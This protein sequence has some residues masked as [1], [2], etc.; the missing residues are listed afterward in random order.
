MEDKDIAQPELASI[1]L[2]APVSIVVPTFREVENIPRLIERIAALAEAYDA[3]FELIFADDN[4]QDGSVEAVESCGYPWVRILVRTE[5]PGLS[6]SVIDGMKAA[7]HPA[8]V[9]M[10]C[11]LSHPPERVP[12]LILALQS[13]QQFVIGSR[14]VPGGSTDDDWGLF[15]WLNSRIAT[16]LARPLTDSKDPMAGFF[17]MRKVDFDNAKDLNPVGYKIA[18]ELIVKC[19]LENVGEVPIHFRDRDLG[20]SKLTLRQQLLYIQHLRRLYIYKFST[21]MEL[22]QFL[23]VGSSGMI[24]NL[25][26]LTL[27]SLMGAPDGLA[28]LGGIVVSVMSNFLLNRRFTFGYARGGNFW[29]QMVGYFTVTSMG[30]TINY[31]VAYVMR[32]TLLSGFGLG[33]QLSAIIGIGAGMAFNFLGNRFFVFKRRSYVRRAEA[34]VDQP[35]MGESGDSV[36]DAGPTSAV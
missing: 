22:L 17:A 20:E 14:Y 24:V 5:D 8:I 6:Q 36:N 18:L 16:V 25:V 11:D 23:A 1:R 34:E 26:T 29:K 35:G 7:S 3:E 27:L 15:R 33:L 21:A 10:D 30:A 12:H 2:H 9:C 19:R 4:S 28:L 13:G 32:Q 31:I